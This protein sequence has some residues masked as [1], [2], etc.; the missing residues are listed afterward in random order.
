ML[1]DPIWL[2]LPLAVVG[3]VAGAI[4]SVSGFGIG[5][6]LTPAL[7][8]R[9]GT[10]LAVAGRVSGGRAD[11]PPCPQPL[12]R[13]GVSYAGQCRSRCRT[14]DGNVQGSAGPARLRLPE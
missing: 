13:T 12:K 6:L 14:R 3:F 1:S 5:S 10:E 2:S 11:R 8:V 9:V 7:A 4:A